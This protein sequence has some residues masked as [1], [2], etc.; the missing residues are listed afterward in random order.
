MAIS[1]TSH[2]PVLLNEVADWSNV[3]SAQIVVD[4]TLGGGGHARHLLNKLASTAHLIGVDRDPEAIARA[5]LAIE[6]DLAHRSSNSP[7]VHFFQ[8]SYVELPS[9][10][11]SLGLG[12]AD[13]ILLDLGLSSDQLASTERGFSF[14][15]SGM[16]DLRFDPTS[17]IPAYE[18][19]AR[20][21]EQEIADIIY[22]FGEERFGRR[23][24]R[25]I[26][27]QRKQSPLET[28]DQLDQLIHRVVPGRIH[29]RVDAST[30]TFQ[31]L[32]IAVNRELEHLEKALHR[33]PELLNPGG[34]LLIISFHSLEDRLVKN[35]FRDHPLLQRL[36]KKPVVATSDECQSNPR[37]RSAKL[38]VAERTPG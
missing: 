27:A 2:V 5:R 9:I 29:G 19:L 38:R 36:T 15:T 13:L 26:V 8:E 6:D 16:L 21:R 10:L 33:L 1:P 7:L 30:R 35:A 3:S 18:L 20:A 12:R 31:A 28:A 17:G 25:A 23:I 37:A 22:H 4:G 32:R 34:R 14:K 24:A 11:E